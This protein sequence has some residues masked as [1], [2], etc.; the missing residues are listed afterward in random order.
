MAEVI[1]FISAV[2]GLV[3]LA[4]QITKLSYGY[5]SDVR[6]AKRTR[7]QYLAELSAL[8]DVL[9]RAEQA[10]LDAERHGLVAPRPTDLSAEVLDDCHQ[11]LVLLRENLEGRAPDGR[12][13]TRLKS[14]FLWPLEEQQLKKHIDTLHRFRSIFADYVSASTLAISEAS[15]GQ[16]DILS[17]ERDRSQLM[18]WLL[19]TNPPRHGPP[20]EPACPGTGQ[21][22][23]ESDVYL[24]W[25]TGAPSV[26]WCRGKPGVGKSMLSSVVLQDLSRSSVVV[27]YFCDFG[28]GKQQTTTLILQTLLRQ[29]LLRGND[30][31]ISALKRCR[32]RF[33][34]PPT[35]KELFQAAIDM[36]RLH[37][38]GMYIVLDALD[39]LE[40]RRI[41][42]PLLNE[43]VRVGCHVFATSRHIPDIA[44]VLSTSVQ[45]ELEAN[46]DDLKIFVESELQESD[47]LNV[48]TNTSGIVDT[49]IDQA[50]GIFLLARL[51]MSHLL[52]LTTMKQ[53]RQSLATLPS[54]LTSAY[55]SSLDR[56]L[57]QPPVRAALALRVIAWIIHAER[58]LT[59]AELLHAFAVEDDVDEI[60]EENFTSASM[61][62]QVCVGLVIV[63]DDTTISLVHAT[64]HTFF[65][66]MPERFL[67]A[68]EDMANTCLRYLC[69][70]NPFGA[71]PCNDV[72]EMKARLHKMPFLAYAAHYWGRHARR[73][74][75]LLSQQIHKLLDNTSLRASSFQAL[76]YRT[77]LDPQL[78][79]ASFA[80]LPTGQEPLHVVACWDLGETAESYIDDNVLSP[81]DAQGWTPLHWACFKGSAIVR[82]RLLRR[83][84][85]VDM[86]DSHGWTPLFWASFNGDVEGL[87]SLLD[88]GADHLVKDISSWTSL[89]WAVSCGS[90]TA[91]ETLL[92]HHAQFLACEAK[93]SPVPVAALSVAEARRRH[94]AGSMVPVEIAAE[95]GDAGLVAVLLQGFGPDGV[96]SLGFNEAWTKGRFDPTMTNLWRAMSKDERINGPESFL[97]N[98]AAKTMDVRD[99]RSR[100]LHAAIRDNKIVM[101]RLLLELGADPNYTVYGRTALYTAAFRK[102]GGFVEMLLGSGADPTQYY[103]SYGYTA[104]HQAII[105]GFEETVAALIKG[106]ADVNA[107]IQPIKNSQGVSK[108]Y[109][110]GRMLDATT[111]LMLVCG[112]DLSNKEDVALPTRIAR[113]LLTAGADLTLVNGSGKPAI[114]YA[115]EGCDLSLVKLL[116]ENGATIPASDPDG[117][118]AI[119]TFAEGRGHMRSLEDLQSLL[120]LLLERL[121]A[122]A[123]SMQ[124]HQSVP[125]P[126]G[127]E[128]KVYC[129]LSLAIKSC[130]WDIFTALL[131]R[132]A[133]LQTTEP[134]EPLLA[135]SIQQ[136]CPAA[137]RFLLDHGAM[138]AG[139]DASYIR[140]ILWHQSDLL[141]S[142]ETAV[143]A[144]R[145]ILRD[146]VQCG[147]DINSVDG[148]Y[149]GTQSALLITVKN[150]DL[151]EIV[152]TLLDAGAD[153]Y[154]TDNNG[155]DA[156]ILSALHE[157]VPTLSCLLENTAKI[158][159]AGHWTQ[160][161]DPA[162]LDPFHDPIA[163]ICACLKQHNLVTQRTKASNKTLLQLAVNAG[164]AQAVAHLL[165]CGADVDDPDG[166]GWTALHTAIFESHRAVVD[167]LLAAGADIHA[168]TEKWPDGHHKPTCLYEGDVWTGQA[169]HLAAMTGD[170]RIVAELLARGADVRAS[171]GC[172]GYWTGHGPTALHIVLDTATF[173]GRRGTPLCRERLEIA[174][175]LVERGADVQGVANHLRLSDVLRFEG[176]E[177]LWNKLRVGVSD[178]G[179]TIQI[180]NV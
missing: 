158:P 40:D 117:C 94:S 1:G 69:M 104:L 125:Y 131:K 80:A 77:R 88:R 66:D 21:W 173:Y 149:G 123:E 115:V 93:Q 103:D 99:W 26:L 53:I 68:H 85:P 154:Q 41:L 168:A 76:Q 59:T 6:D 145:L 142:D 130:N 3:A 14:T 54:N 71:G 30:S 15:Y 47:F 134:L 163:Y 79:E 61:L 31:H 153:L 28:A 91:V 151:P 157:K 174:T 136:L 70:R 16:L 45:V 72:L 33:S 166:Y 73:V 27:H 102:D 50:G 132:G 58:R 155:L 20:T 171:T 108:Y 44:D 118:C 169:L 97:R 143:D 39:E 7:G 65:A 51:L 139:S 29:M 152:Q 101:V 135:T 19:P 10:A 89:Q 22:F 92:N 179:Q 82:E 37:P 172:H 112:F 57:A 177:D 114:H 150:F 4:G 146:L 100:L 11:Q 167:V 60:D 34:T 78:A 63:N 83:E 38:A 161:L 46:H 144:F 17:R 23:I 32:E 98:V 106:G 180:G 67:N 116:L 128:A 141:S 160:P 120:D 129:P 109:L 64:A 133:H 122:G 35:F 126:V 49:V 12:S 48:N 9:L 164:S 165:A 127:S 170:A 55:E 86:R 137:V 113:L 56:V 162:G 138:P 75:L 62:L 87:T 178:K 111:P 5:L 121:P 156:F 159:R 84:A 176:F 18:E 105:N 124:C 119:H 148:F 96:S 107:R 175:M 43:F 13:L 74:E 95:T 24:R 81:L 52:T 2:A 110:D 147:V 8:T 140:E 42:L 90:R 25:R 36:C